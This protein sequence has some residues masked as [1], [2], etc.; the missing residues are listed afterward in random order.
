M[1][2]LYTDSSSAILLERSALFDQLLQHARVVMSTA[3]YTEITKPGYPGEDR[4]KTDYH[5][6]RF[7]VAPYVKWG[8]KT[9]SLLNKNTDLQQW[10]IGERET[11][12][13]YLKNRDGYIL[14]DDGKAARWCF[15]HDIPFIN[16]LLVPKIFRYGQL[17][18]EDEYASKFEKLC[19]IGRYS[20]KIKSF[21]RD[22]TMKDLSY[23]IELMFHG[24]QFKK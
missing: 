5:S 4:F 22:C 13:L 1:A 24:K 20:Q 3:V 12:F 11:I 23:F 18:S 21:A 14:I 8:I 2:F 6:K 15:K 16:A 7:S 17:I 10:G 9:P 19:T